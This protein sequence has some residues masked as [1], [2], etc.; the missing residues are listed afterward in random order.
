MKNCDLCKELNTSLYDTPLQK[1]LGSNS[2]FIHRNDYFNLIPA[3]GAL[4]EG[5]VMI[6]PHFHSVSVIDLKIDIVK[7][8]DYYI[9]YCCNLVKKYY[10]S[11][12]VF[13]HGIRQI[14]ARRI[15]HSHIHIVPYSIKNSRDFIFNLNNRY[16]EKY[17]MNYSNFKELNLTEE[18]NYIYVKCDLFESIYL[19]S[20]PVEY[21][22]RLRQEIS[23]HVDLFEGWDWALNIGKYE[24]E[25]INKIKL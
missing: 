19:D 4:W 16:K 13:E 23:K 10:G 12:L 6:V 8:L 7:K 11:V 25:T 2:R 14:N 1:V 21:R 3:L 15:E 5:H 24:Y 9:T 17:F 18:K 20:D 22:I